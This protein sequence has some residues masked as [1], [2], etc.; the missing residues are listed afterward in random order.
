MKGIVTNRG[1]VD[2]DVAPD[3]NL[4]VTV[5]AMDQ[6]VHR[7]QLDFVALLQQSTDTG[8]VEFGASVVQ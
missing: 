6:G 8:D 5:F 2:V 3:C 7:A 1:A 4:R